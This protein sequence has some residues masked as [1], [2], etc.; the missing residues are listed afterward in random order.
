MRRSMQPARWP[1][2]AESGRSNGPARAHGQA[3]H[4]VEGR[5]LAAGDVEDAGHRGAGEGERALRGLPRYS[6]P[7]IRIMR[8]MTAGGAVS[9]AVS[10]TR[11]PS[12]WATIRTGRS[13]RC[14]VDGVDHPPEPAAGVMARSATRGRAPVAG[15]PK[16]MPSPVPGRSRCRWRGQLTA[17]QQSRA[18]GERQDMA[19][20]VVVG[21]RRAEAVA[22]DQDR[23]GVGGGSVASASARVVFPPGRAPG[24]HP[25]PHSH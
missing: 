2:P 17:F 13:G 24:P 6:A 21:L 20:R 23:D 14:A 5:V 1:S 8:R 12:E 7:E 15:Q 19:V 10:A 22:V 11:A 4:Q 9:S 16:P 25:L 18:G 3:E